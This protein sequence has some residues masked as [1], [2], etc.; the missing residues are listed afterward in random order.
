M[1]STADPRPPWPPPLTTTPWTFHVISRLRRPPTWPRSSP[2]PPPLPGAALLFVVLP[3][4]RRE[5]R[6]SISFARPSPAWARHHLPIPP[7]ADLGLKRNNEMGICFL[8]DKL[9]SLRGQ[10]AVM[11]AGPLLPVLAVA[12]LV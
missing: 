9:R 12:F 7:C 10:M 11:V 6:P 5:Q 1:A 4:V 2:A 8:V 3:R